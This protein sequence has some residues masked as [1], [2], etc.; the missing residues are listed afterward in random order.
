MLK[1]LFIGDIVG[2]PGRKCVKYVFDNL[3]DRKNYD[4]VIA[5]GENLAGGKGISKSVF[6]EILSYGV[7]VVTLGNH[8]FSRKEVEEIINSPQLIRP[9]NYPEG[10]Q[11]QGYCIITT[12][13]NIDV[14]I[15]NLLGRVFTVECLD[16]PF[17]TINNLIE[18]I[19]NRTNVIIV[20][21]HAEVTSEKNA[22]GYFLDGKVTAVVGT[23]THVPTNDAKILPN[24]TGYITDVGMCGPENSVIGLEIETVIK[25]FLL[26]VPQKF[27]VAKGK[28]QFNAVELYVDEVTGKT[29]QIKQIIYNS[30]EI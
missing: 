20:D 21:F 7:D 3:L 26:G 11:G 29:K 17:R 12:K 5:N 16:C 24:G 19:K 30:I 22:M 13:N 27:N 28:V 2:E 8:T 10:N 15:V 9:L 14:C 18:E 1:I 6:E 4:V 23:H 25:R